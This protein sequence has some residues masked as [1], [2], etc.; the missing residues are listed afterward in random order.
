M[1]GAT[2]RKPHAIACPIIIIWT[3]RDYRRFLTEATRLLWTIRAQNSGESLTELSDHDGTGLQSL[4]RKQALIP[5]AHSE[6][7]AEVHF[8][9]RLQAHQRLAS[10]G[11]G[12]VD[13]TS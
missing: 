3:P 11:R 6:R 13:F 10:S 12:A 2:S 9:T 5:A 4:R 8:S 7:P 1:L